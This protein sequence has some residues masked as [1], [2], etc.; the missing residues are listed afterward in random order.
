MINRAMH[1]ADARALVN[2][3]ECPV[4]ILM[5]N[6]FINYFPALRPPSSLSASAL[7]K[8]AAADFVVA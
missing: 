4:N 5:A 6:N 7:V 1:C 2:F 8:P 3:L